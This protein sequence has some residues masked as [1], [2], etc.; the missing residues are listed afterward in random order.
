[1][2]PRDKPRHLA[3]KLLAIREHLGLSQ[4]QCVKRLGLQMAYSRISEFEL[5]RRFPPV[6][7][8]LAYARAAGVHVDDLI[9]DDINLRL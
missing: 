7:V 2:R 8:L 6:Y 5:G 4:T 1:M 9:D 3:E